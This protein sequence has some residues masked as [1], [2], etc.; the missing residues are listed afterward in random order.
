MPLYRLPE[1]IGLFEGPYLIS[2]VIFMLCVA[3]VFRWR[4]DRVLLFSAA[5]FFF[6]IFFILRYG[7]W[8][9]NTNTVA[10]RFIYLPSLGL[11]VIS[12]VGGYALFNF[13][14][15]KGRVFALI[16]GVAFVV[17]V[18]YSVQAPPDATHCS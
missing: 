17:W 5:F 12:V 6:S 11:C 18:G 7:A 16:Y 1:P 4:R 9:K 2:L 13:F 14:K 3:A 8:V 15:A 10:D